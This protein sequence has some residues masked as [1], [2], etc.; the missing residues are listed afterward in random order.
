MH[1]ACRWCVH[2]WGRKSLGCLGKWNRTMGKVWGKAEAWVP[3]ATALVGWQLNKMVVSA[4]PIYMEGMRPPFGDAP[5]AHAIIKSLLCDVDLWVLK[6]MQ[7]TYCKQI[8]PS[9]PLL[10]WDAHNT[11][12]EQSFQITPCLL[13]W[14]FPLWQA[15]IPYPV[16]PAWIQLSPNSRLH[17][18]TCWQSPLASTWPLFPV[19]NWTGAHT[20]GDIGGVVPNSHCYWLLHKAIIGRSHANIMAIYFTWDCRS[21]IPSHL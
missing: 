19:D 12:S 20:H 13:E 1:L 6:A 9:P 7:K 4:R 21:D 5:I 2:G 15:K 14:T 10:T 18:L 16:R 8:A 3:Q 11:K 17:E